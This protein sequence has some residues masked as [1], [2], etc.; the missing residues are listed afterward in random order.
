MSTTM[1]PVSLKRIIEVCSISINNVKI[2]EFMISEKLDVSYRRSREIIKEL[3]NLK[4]LTSFENYYIKNENTAYLINA[5]K[6]EEW[7]KISNYLY[8][9]NKLYSE[10]ILYLKKNEYRTG[11]DIMELK[12]TLKYNTTITELL[13]NWSE[14]LNIIQKNV[15]KNTYYYV[16][17]KMQDTKLFRDSLFK[18][19]K[20]LNKKIGIDH[21]LIYIEIP[22][23]REQVCEDLKIK[24]NIFDKLLISTYYQHIS[25]IELTGAPMITSAKIS[26]SGIKDMK[27]SKINQI[28]SSK[29]NYE[30]E[31]KGLVI[32]G[33]NY[34]YIA[35]H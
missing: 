20:I 14:R 10:F 12:N 1:R 33:K 26:P 35:I 22:K 9:N 13:I 28:L 3:I 2:D 31:R 25:K 32:Q 6:K 23:L 4:L 16:H 34:W 30:K 24:R 5:F 29:I 27:I 11:I 8:K 17:N 19:Y 7:K 21:K 18:N 15:Y